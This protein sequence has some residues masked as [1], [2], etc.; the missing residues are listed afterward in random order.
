V[1]LP[2]LK[3][4]LLRAGAWRQSRRAKASWKMTNNDRRLNS[5]KERL[6]FRVCVD[7]GVQ[8]I[9]KTNALFRV[10]RLSGK[11]LAALG[12]VPGQKIRVVT[13]GSV[14]TIAPVRL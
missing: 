4:F 7:N 6:P 9:A 11:W 13:N 3:A 2:I 12:L 14:I 10:S 8:R 1:A 5:A